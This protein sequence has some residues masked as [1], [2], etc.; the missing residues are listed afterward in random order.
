MNNVTI[1]LCMIV[2]DEEHCLERCLESAKHLVDEIIIVDTGSTDRTKHIARRYTDNV[3]DFEWTENFAAARNYA[4]E[5]ASSA[6]IL[7]LDADEIIIDNDN[8]LKAGLDKDFY[9]IT[10][11]NNVD[12]GQ[13]IVHQFARVFKN[14][15]KYRYVGELHEQIPVNYDTEEWGLLPCYIEHDGYLQRNVQL[16]DKSN[17]NMRI[18]KKAT[19]QNPSA[20][21]YFNLGAQY[22]QENRYLEALEV[23]KK[24]YASVEHNDLAQ[25]V[26]CQ[27]VKCLYELKRWDEAIQLGVDA[28]RLYPNSIDLSFL[29]G[30]CYLEVH[31]VRDAEKCFERCLTIG[32]N[33][34]AE[35]LV[36]QAG[37]ESYLALAKLAETYML[38]DEPD[39][40]YTCLQDALLLVP[41]NKMITQLLLEV[42]PNISYEELQSKLAPVLPLN[43]QRYIS[44]I[45]ALYNLRNPLIVQFIESSSLTVTG[46]TAVLYYLF[47]GDYEL[48]EQELLKAKD[49]DNFKNHLKDVLL[50]GLLSGDCSV[51]QAM[52]SKFGLSQQEVKW[53]QQLLTQGEPKTSNLSSNLKLIWRQLVE[54]LLHLHKYELLEKLLAYAVEPEMRYIMSER[55]V[56]FGFYEAALDILVEGKHA[57]FNYDVYRLAARALEKIGHTSDSLFY[58][59]QAIKINRSMD[60]LYRMWNLF[61]DNI[62]EQQRLLQEMKKLQPYSD[63]VHSY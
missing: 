25:R 1:S 14:T 28:L 24:S 54:D 32:N 44:L 58:Y 29:L 13:F 27:I 55:F 46:P 43:Q 22:M 7:Q 31:Y 9:H 36:Y 19:A 38:D 11:H 51:F 63:W 61:G 34:K 26:V 57:A 21:N 56:A 15:P 62:V 60:C 48:V 37:A 33:A 17:R 20:F 30:H 40:A 59:Q 49:K 50:L 8:I 10:I 23:L 47:K 5:Q 16:K 35:N 12:S 41:D 3:Y 45:G 6:Y 53:L 52:K 39:K 2:K 4:I 42:R 18:L